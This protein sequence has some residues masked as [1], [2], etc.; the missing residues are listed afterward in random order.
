MDKLGASFD[1]SIKSIETKLKTIPLPVQIP[2][3]EEKSFIGVIDLVNMN[4]LTWNNRNSEKDFG[5]SFET[6]ALNENDQ[7][8][9]KAMKS[10]TSMIEK[11]AQVNEEFAE[12]LLEKYNLDYEKMNDNEL[13]ETHLRKS[14]IDLKITPVLCGSS[15]RNMSVQPLMDAIVKYLPSPIELPKNNF[16]DFYQNDLNAFC[17]KIIHDHQKSRK[18]V[19]S[20]TAIASLNASGASAALVK[21]RSDDPDADIL[22]YVRV[23]NGELHSK[24]KVFNINKQCKEIIDKIYVPFSNQVKQVSK[25]SM[26]NIALVSGLTQV[27]KSFNF[28]QINLADCYKINCSIVHLKRC[29]LKFFQ[30][31]IQWTPVYP[32]IKY[33]KKNN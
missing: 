16:S 1:K 31:L 32:I 7:I 11:L 5:K 28:F 6:K 22:T 19:N 27:R 30:L 24:S 3:G 18:R 29:V 4:K 21:S 13:L 2:I 9:S 12:I 33:L 17:F 8:Y 20:T 15:L 25:V 26:G 14:N 10:R 23:Y